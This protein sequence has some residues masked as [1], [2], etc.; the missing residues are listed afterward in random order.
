MVEGLKSFLYV[1]SRGRSIQANDVV[2]NTML[3]ESRH[4]ILK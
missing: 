1:P 3:H 4:A 2:L